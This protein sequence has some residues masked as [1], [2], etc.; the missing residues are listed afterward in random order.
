MIKLLKNCAMLVI[1][2]FSL[3]A[4]ANHSIAIIVHPDNPSEFDERVARQIFLGQVKSF[5]DGKEAQAYAAKDDE[6][7]RDLFVAKVLRRNPH[8]MNAY[9]A[10]MI[11]TAKATP[12]REL[13]D[14]EAV[15]KMVSNSA[16]AISYIDTKDVDESI[17]V[18]AIV[19]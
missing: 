4:H 2:S 16:H 9:W 8:T 12:P 7:L 5:P 3:S 15:K 11:F 6:E 17:R 13:P 19:E 1:L 10:R 14:T 18:I